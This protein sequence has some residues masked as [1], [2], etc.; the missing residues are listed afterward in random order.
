MLTFKGMC[1]LL[2]GKIDTLEALSRL[3]QN[4]ALECMATLKWP[5]GT[6][7]QC[8]SVS[9]AGLDFALGCTHGQELKSKAASVLVNKIHQELQ[10]KT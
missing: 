4:T 5:A 8:L 6:G 10:N 7:F 3:L 9:A 1:L 2:V